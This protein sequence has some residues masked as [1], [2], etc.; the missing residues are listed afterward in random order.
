MIKVHD[1][2]TNVIIKSTILYNECF[3]QYTSTHINPKNIFFLDM[4]IKRI[5]KMGNYYMSIQGIIK[6]RSKL[7]HDRLK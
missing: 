1:P 5:R 2:Y 4:T 3:V 7:P 6:I